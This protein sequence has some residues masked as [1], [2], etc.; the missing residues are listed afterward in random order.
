M[1]TFSLKFWLNE[2]NVW[3]A[4]FENYRNSIVVMELHS[5]LKWLF[6]APFGAVRKRLKSV[7]NRDNVVM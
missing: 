3:A 6:S 1:E 2:Q 7:F 4:D 5:R